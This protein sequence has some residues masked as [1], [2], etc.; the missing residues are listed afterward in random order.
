MTSQQQ[1]RIIQLLLDLCAFFSS[2]AHLILSPFQIGEGYT[3]YTYAQKYQQSAYLA[4]EDGHHVEYQLLR[5]LT[6][7]A[8]VERQQIYSAVNG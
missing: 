5:Y 7:L 2:L 3:K 4:E 1:I 6:I 8:R